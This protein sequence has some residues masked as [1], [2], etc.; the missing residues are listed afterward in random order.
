[1][2]IDERLRAIADALP[3]DGRVSF[4]RTDL[5]NMIAAGATP[6]EPA[7]VSV[8]LTVAEVAELLHRAPGTIRGWCASGEL[9]GAYRLRGREWRIP[10]A[11]VEAFQRHQAEQ[12]LEYASSSSRASTALDADLDA[13]RSARSPSRRSGRRHPGRVTSVGEPAA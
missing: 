4:T 8:D 7:Q 5:L 6:K 1:M 13:W 2:L 12:A 10:T 11:A 9:P 3:E